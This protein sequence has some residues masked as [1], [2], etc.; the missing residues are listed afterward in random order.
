MPALSSPGVGSG[1][2]VNGIVS[3]LMAVE[4]QP[5]TAL[6]QRTQQYQAKLSAFGQ[7]KSALAGFQGALQKLSGADRF[8]VL[9]ATSSDPAVV[10][11]SAGANAVPA[12]Y[13]IEVQQ[14]AQ[15]QKLASNGFASTTA[16]VGTGTLTIQFGTYD[17][18]SNSFALN[19]NK[20]AAS[21][22]IDS[23]NNSLA[24][25]RDA[26]NAAHAGVTASIVNDGTGNR[27][28]L[29][30]TDSGA[31][32]GIKLTVADADGND[33]DAAGL[34]AL[35][36]DPT[37]SAGN[38][39]N[40][41]EV[42]AARNALFSVDGIAISQ[43]SNVV[44]NA[45][46]GVT[47]TLAKTNVGQPATLAVKRDTAAITAAV[48][49]F[50]KAYND[51][52]KTLKDLTAWDPASKKG[53]ALQGD[54]T[55]RSIQTTLRGM[56]NTP[57]VTGGSL[58]TLSQIGV[59]FQADG[60]LA[61]DSATLGNA[62][63]SHFGDVAALFAATGRATDSLVQFSASSA[64]TRPGSY[65]LA[66]SQV[67]TQ[68]RLVGSQPATLAIVA[69]VNDAL[70]L[71]VNGSPVSVTLAAGVYP[72]AAALAAALQ[73]GINGALGSA[74]VT[75]SESGGVLAIGANRYGSA[76]SVAITGGNGA[77]A[78]FGAAPLASTGVDVAGTLDGVAA[79]GV[80]Q[81]L[82][83]A[84]GTP[85]E[86]LALRILGGATGARG[87]VTFGRGF[88]DQLNTYV[89]GLLDGDGLIA[90]RTDG[91]NASIKG[92]DR[93]QEALQAR[94]DQIEKRYRAQFTA[95]DTMLSSMNKT[96]SFLTQQLD[97]LKALQ[98]SK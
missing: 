69:G 73:V 54:S 37:A 43:A 16:A 12:S 75:V 38:G 27:L 68:G 98:S 85:A 90:A 22:T 61:L 39:K 81:T 58:T 24:G 96:S 3:Q 9:A 13:Q 36:Y 88:A 53:G 94:L 34:S 26:I 11:A 29:T 14:L 2:D 55:I 86:G 7:V 49:D 17:S 40:L 76:S 65:A 51:I 72:D 64:A 52:A 97:S 30:S 48:G 8:Q 60:T 70:D 71:S 57:A 33:G 80:G 5:L 59:R 23:S 89:S 62:I 93:R 21:V 20:P 42:A 41:A 91:I 31:A 74:A 56:L 77:A 32:N 83:G 4:R 82:T 87:S 50:V 1:L 46:E 18:G 35:A 47:L 19:P 79:S 44:A 66:V 10:S 6:T 92:L 15:Q 67:A 25:I 84:A 63:D 28:V 95:L 45:I 78:L